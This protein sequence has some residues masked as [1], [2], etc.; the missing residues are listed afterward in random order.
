MI[1][2]SD[3]TK[4]ENDKKQIAMPQVLKHIDKIAREKKC[5]VDFLEFHPLDDFEQYVW[6]KDEVRNDVLWYLNEIGIVWEKCFGIANENFMPSYLGQIYL[7]IPKN[8]DDSL[9]AKLEAYLENTDGTMQIPSVRF[10]CVPLEMAMKNA[11]HDEPDFYEK[12]WN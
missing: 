6:Q 2:Y 8:H 4:Q 10:Y 11:H 7:D 3:T 9:Y 5:D 12:Q 1:H